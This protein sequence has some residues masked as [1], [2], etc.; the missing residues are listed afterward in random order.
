MRIQGVSNVV[1]CHM[2]LTTTFYFFFSF[3]YTTSSILSFCTYYAH[4]HL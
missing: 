4:M 2:C 3:F 1:T